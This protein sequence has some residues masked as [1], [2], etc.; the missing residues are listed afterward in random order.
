MTSYRPS[1]LAIFA[2]WQFVLRRSWALTVQQVIWNVPDGNSSDFTDTYTNGNTLNLSWNSWLSTSYVDA[3][4]NLVDL[5]VVGFD[6]DVNPRNYN[7]RFKLPA[8]TF[9]DTTGDLSSPGFLITPDAADIA[10]ES[11][12]SSSATSSA[13]KS[14]TSST[15][16]ST[17]SSTIS[18]T[19]GPSTSTSGTATGTA[20][21]STATLNP[22]TSPSSGMSAGAKAGIAIGVVAVVAGLAGLGYYAFMLRRKLRQQQNNIPSNTS[23]AMMQPQS[24]MM[25]SQ[26]NFMQSPQD[27]Y[28]YA[29]APTRPA[30]PV[31]LASPWP[32]R[33]LSANEYSPATATYTSR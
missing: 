18:S 2:I 3:E 23:S 4:H 20:S 13:T 9:D 21:N 1:V 33:E 32:A 14:A 24:A 12:S 7:V 17:A 16:S 26:N 8:N 6:F 19:T 30:D 15:A 10:A 25:Q 28:V 22:V 11:S 29:A 27:K 5:W 31:E